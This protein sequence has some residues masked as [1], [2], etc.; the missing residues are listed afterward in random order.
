MNSLV[1]VILI[2]F[3]AAVLLALL[4]GRPR[5]ERAVNLGA[6]GVLCAYV[7][8]LLAYVDAHGIQ[9][10][11][12]AGY[13]APYGI[14]FVA[15]RL[16]CFMLCLAAI[17][18]TVALL[19]SLPSLSAKQER[20]FFHPLFQILLTGVN[21]SFI[22]G[23]LF[24][25]FVA[26][27]VMLVGSYGCLMVGASRPQ[28]RQAL[29]YIAINQLGGALFVVAVGLVYATVGTL[30]LADLAA[31]TAALEGSRAAIVTAVS[32][33]L[34][35]VF[36]LKS[37]SFPLFIWLPDSYPVVPAGVN[38]YFAGLLTKVGI[39][40]LLRVFVMTFQQPGRELPLNVLLA[41]SGFTMLLGVLGALCQWEMRRILSWHIISQIGYMLMGIG[42]AAHVGLAPAAVVAT[43]FFLGHNVIVKSSLFM[44]AG[45]AEAVSGARKLKEMGG[46]AAL[47]PM[48]AAGFLIAAFSLAGMP[49]FTGFIGK[50]LLMQA[51]L[52]AGR[53][54][55]V[56]IAVLTSFCTLLSMLK[57][58]SY[59]FWRA[60]RPSTAVG[61]WGRMA[62]PTAVL[63]ALTVAFGVWG[64]PVLRFLGQAA[65]EITQPSAYV[66]AVLGPHPAATG[67][68]AP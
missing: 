20:Y 68:G 5:L 32:M 56:A 51:G 58:W 3:G 13:P 65:T 49:P 57:M 7:F 34:L 4:N 62:A 23:D 11:A 24:N 1:L 21:W 44:L 10:A 47:A 37:A 27:E 48:L 59:A 15:D 52:A 22:T 2:P 17:V 18:G 64:Q 30:N 19:V 55:I 28:I 63:V 53:N 25:L 6:C 43:V 35:V 54:W 31:R 41:V 16:A 45:A 8:W 38:G 36:A 66:T 14:A 39:Y 61:G 33:I 50:L 42:L 9:A 67:G 29:T 46:V 12:I 40:S 26:Y 60:P